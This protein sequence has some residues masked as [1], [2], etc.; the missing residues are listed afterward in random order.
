MRLNPIGQQNINTISGV[1]Q[2]RGNS[3]KKDNKTNDFESEM[4]DS[5]LNRLKEAY[6]EKDTRTMK[7]AID[8][9]LDFAK[10]TD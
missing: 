6:D 7:Q 8:I 5:A 4:F 2:M 1:G 9:L 3:N 10:D